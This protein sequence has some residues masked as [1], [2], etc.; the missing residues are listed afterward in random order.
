[1][2]GLFQGIE[3]KK[4]SFVFCSHVEE[5]GPCFVNADGKTTVNNPFR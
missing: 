2:I 4:L 1:M 5:H 3:L